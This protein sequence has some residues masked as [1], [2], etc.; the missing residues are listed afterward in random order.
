MRSVRYGILALILSAWVMLPSAMAA[1][2]MPAWLPDTGDLDE[3]TLLQSNSTSVENFIC[4]A[5][6]NISIYTQLWYLNS[7]TTEVQALIG[8]VFVDLPRDYM[9]DN[10]STHPLYQFPVLWNLFLIATGYN[11]EEDGW[12]RWD[13]YVYLLDLM[14]PSHDATDV[15]AELGWDRAV[16]I[17]SGASDHRTFIVGTINNRFIASFGME[18]TG[19]YFGHRELAGAVLMGLVTWWLTCSAAFAMICTEE[20]VAETLEMGSQD[21]TEYTSTDDLMAFNVAIGDF[22][23]TIPWYIWVIIAGGVVAIAILGIVIYRKRVC[24]KGGKSVL[25]KGITPADK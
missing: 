3:Y 2:T 17:T 19:S 14:S 1:E 11:P 23:T 18:L 4:N 6:D 13:M 5:D 20:Y 15:A 12:T 9:G 8:E 24:P 22:F 10:V 25:C 7:S 16:R 21:V